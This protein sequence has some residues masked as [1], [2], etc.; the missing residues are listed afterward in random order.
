MK[1]L[2]VTDAAPPQVNG[3]VR[4][5]TQLQTECA[6]LG[7]QVDFITPGDCFTLPN[8]LYPEVRLSLFAA[9]NIR[10]YLDREQPDAVH[11]AT[12][13]PLGCAA[14]RV[15]I[16][17]NL[18]FTTSYHTNF[19]TYF[20]QKMRVPRAL[21]YKVIRWFHNASAGVMV[22]TEAVKQELRDFNIT[23]L[24]DWTRGVDTSL[25]RPTGEKIMELK[26]PVY[27]HVG[28]VSL[29]KNINEF[30]DLD[31]D[32]TKVVIG[33]G[34]DLENLKK[35]Y[36]DA[37]FTGPKFGEELVQYYN[38]G[39]VF[40]FP[41]RFD[42][43]GLVLLEALACGV[44]VAAYPVNGPIDVI[45]DSGAGVLDHDLRKAVEGA[46]KISP[47]F[48]R[49][50]ASSFSWQNCAQQFLDNLVLIGDTRKAA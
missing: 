26:G 42:T 1:I 46:L 48:C 32:G 21:S 37:I 16:K 25:F 9:K 20:Y 5:L 34:P 29:E 7:H 36:P 39:D 28:R 23:N 12:E 2:I 40:V 15:C 47:D 45:G 3:V 43:F 6:E 10:D 35:K 14:R 24:M 17:E 11:I 18:A 8:P 31:L 38:L 49:E 13:G 19:P 4:T 27:I 50:Y 44:P 33:G 22:A 30:L 41:S